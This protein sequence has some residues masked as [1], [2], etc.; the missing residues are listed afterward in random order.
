MGFYG[1]ARFDR[2]RRDPRE[3]GYWLLK[4]A[5]RHQHLTSWGEVAAVFD[6]VHAAADGSWRRYL[7]GRGSSRQPPHVHL[8]LRSLILA[9]LFG[10]PITGIGRVLTDGLNGQASQTIVYP[11]G[12]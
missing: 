12:W 9:V 5:Q 11:T 6:A 2:Y 7:S 8:N 4:H 1:T 3:K 10:Q